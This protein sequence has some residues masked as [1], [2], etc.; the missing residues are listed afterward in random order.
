MVEENVED[1]KVAEM[2]E[3]IK[4]YRDVQEPSADGEEAEDRRWLSS[5]LLDVLTVVLIVLNTILIA[6]ETDFGDKEE[7]EVWWFAL[8]GFFCLLFIT[9]IV[10]KVWIHTWRWFVDSWNAWTTVVCLLL[11]I[12]AAILAPLGRQGAL[13]LWSLSRFLVLFRLLRSIRIV[14]ELQHVLNGMTG[15]FPS[16][17]WVVVILI[18]IIYTFSVWTTTL[19]GRNQDYVD[20][21]KISNGYEHEE[22]FGTI[23]RSMFTLMQVVT[24]DSW[25]SSVARYIVDRQWYMS[26]FFIIFIMMTSFSLLNLVVSLIVEQTLAETQRLESRAAVRAEKARRQELESIREIFM[27]ADADYNGELDLKEFLNAVQDQEVLGRLLQLELPVEEATQLFQVM[28]GNGSRSLTMKE[29]IDGCTKLKGPARSKDLLA[30]QAQA[31]TMARQLDM[32]GAEL[33]DTER[34]LAAL[35]DIANRMGNRF[36]PTVQ[37]SRRKIAQRVGGSQ[38]TMPIHGEKR[39]DPAKMH[40][41]STGNKPVLPKFPNL[42]G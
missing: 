17:L 11:F 18:L 20:Y 42:L 38:P 30:V 15:A 26:F 10:L 2:A 39:V 40:D 4:T 6:V 23:G 5:P 24:L 27:L 36:E 41:L 14:K 8:E 1:V 31:D 34:M 37:S 21:Q 35:E 9:E 7:R 22:F 12:D 3:I 13:R 16:L 28:E 33:Q 29:F 32:L 19:I 25:S